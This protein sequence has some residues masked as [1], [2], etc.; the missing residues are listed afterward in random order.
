LCN[1]AKQKNRFAV[2]YTVLQTTTTTTKT[3]IKNNRKSTKMGAAASTI[4]LESLSAEDIGKMVVSIGAAYQPYETL[5]VQNGISGEVLSTLDSTAIKGLL[6]DAGIT[7]AVHQT[8]LC[9]NFKKL[10][11]AETAVATQPAAASA[12]NDPSCC[13]FH[14]LPDDFKVGELVTKTPRSIMCKFFEIQGICVD[15]TDLDPAVEKIAKAVGSGFGDGNSKYDC[16]I[17]YRVATDADLAEKLFLYL[18]N[19]NIFAFLDKKCLKNG[20]KWKD[21]FLTG[22]CIFLFFSS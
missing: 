20:E 16:F 5:I 13:Q 3:K 19:K 11:P 14:Q 15:P 2:S 17:N 4:T 21:G 22:M 1:N 8:V 7:N 10:K 6:T 18:R 9:S 12:K